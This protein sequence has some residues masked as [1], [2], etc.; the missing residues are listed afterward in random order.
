MIKKILIV[1]LI[2][3]VI[4]QLFHPKRNK[5]KGDQPNYIGKSFTVPDDIKSIL[6]RSCND[7]HSNNTNYPW[8][9]NIQPVAWWLNHHIK[10]GKNEINFDEFSNKSLRFQYHKFEEITEQVKEGEMPIN[11]YTWTHKD[12][13]LSEADKSKLMA[14]ADASRDSMKAKYPIDSLVRKKQ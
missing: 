5:S 10:E 12:A 4:I 6:E 2:A 8:Y 9:A 7:C 1:L 13:V 14:W 3:L 11:S